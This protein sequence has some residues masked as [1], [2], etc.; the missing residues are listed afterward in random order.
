MQMN[1]KTS[2]NTV[3][4]QLLY[5]L[6]EHYCIIVQLSLLVPNFIYCDTCFFAAFALTCV[7]RGERYI[8]NVAYFKISMCSMA[9]NIV[10]PF[11]C[12]STKEN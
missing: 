7:Y 1:Q 4:C 2:R 11:A 10:W 5:R 3:E 8:P 12:F 9:R 6:G